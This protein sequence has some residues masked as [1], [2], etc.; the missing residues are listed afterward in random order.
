M[1]LM[2]PFEG[3]AQAAKIPR[4]GFLWFGSRGGPTPLSDGLKRA[5]VERRYVLD[6]NLIIDLRYAEGKPERY[7]ALFAE[8]LASGADLLLAVGNAAALDLRR[9]RSPLPALGAVS[10]E[11]MS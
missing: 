8:L 6:G 5:L 1:A 11:P 7:P 2:W 9:S 4:I 10:Q 3:R